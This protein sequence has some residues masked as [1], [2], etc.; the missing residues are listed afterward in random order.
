MHNAHIQNI[1]IHENNQNI[2][3]IVTILLLL[4]CFYD[5]ESQ[6][7]IGQGYMD[8]TNQKRDMKSNDSTDYTMAADINLLKY[9]E[10]QGKYM[11]IYLILN[12]SGQTYRLLARVHQI[13]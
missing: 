1:I 7:L 3:T 8:S 4:E 13:K 2:K 11:G 9:V 12:V 5:F 10:K 6:L